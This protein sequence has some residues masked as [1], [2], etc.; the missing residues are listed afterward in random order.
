MKEVK[1]LG[2]WA[3]R[4]KISIESH[5]V[6]KWDTWNKTKYEKKV[7]NGELTSEEVARGN[8]NKGL[9][10]EFCVFDEKHNEY[11]YCY[12]AVIPRNKHVG[13]SF[14]DFAGREYLAYQFHEV[15]EDRALFLWEAW[16]YHFTSESVMEEDYRIHFV[17]DEEGNISYR[18]YDDKNQ[19]I[20]DFEGNKKF[21][22]SG[23]YE[24]YPE[25][26]NYDGITRLD[27]DLPLDITPPSNQ[28]KHTTD[29]DW[30]PPGWDEGT[31]PRNE[32]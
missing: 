5:A 17:F 10:Y 23:L 22:V 2:Y 1:Y 3:E 11:P 32:N 20:Q 7:E 21:D 18:K 25:F 16:Y 27:R 13:V 15:K 30:L 4:K 8:H 12:V 24:P 31:L 28:G 26:G 6:S 29:N 9:G 19:E 14:L